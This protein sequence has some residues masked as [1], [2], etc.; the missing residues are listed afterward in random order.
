MKNVKFRGKKTNSAVNSAAK[1][2][3]PQ[4]GSKFRGPQKTVGPSNMQL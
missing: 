1:T 2:Q 3:I 4:L